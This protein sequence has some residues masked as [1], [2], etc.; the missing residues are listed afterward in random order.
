MYS[1]EE[2][3]ARLEY[4]ST[5][6]QGWTTNCQ[7]EPITKEAL[8]RGYELLTELAEAGISPPY[9]FPMLDGGISAEWNFAGGDFEILPNGRLQ[10]ADGSVG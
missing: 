7:G 2:S 8:S 10:F 4:L 9:L 3:Y 1:Y 5:L 6:G